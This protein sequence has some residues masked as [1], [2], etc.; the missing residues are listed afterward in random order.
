MYFN[1]IFL[2]YLQ[3]LLEQC[4]V[5]LTKLKEGLPFPFNYFAAFML[6]CIIGYILKLTFKYIL[7]PSAWGHLLHRNH[8][9][10]AQQ[11]ALTN[12]DAKSHHED[13]ISGE[14]LKLLLNVISATPQRIQ[15]PPVV[16]GVEEL[17]EAIEAAP[18]ANL[19]SL[20]AAAITN[21]T[22]ADESPTSKLQHN[23]NS[24]E[25]VID[26]NTEVTLEDCTEES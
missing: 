21:L 1:D 8:Y 18:I 22:S 11:A 24:N 16:S 23:N 17:K 3:V 10:P 26:R 25:K 5:T 12:A 19:S 9:H 6:I 15:L 4:T 2:K 13:R 20:E 14:N 7:S